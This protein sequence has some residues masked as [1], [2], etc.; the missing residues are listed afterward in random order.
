[1]GRKRRGSLKNLGENSWEIRIQ[2][3]NYKEF[4][5]TVAG[6]EAD[7]RAHL[8][9]CL[10]R[11]AEI[12]RAPEKFITLNVLLDKWLL[13]RKPEIEEK[14]YLGYESS[15]RRYIRPI[16]GEKLIIEIKRAAVADLY[17]DL[18]ARRELSP[19]TIRK[20]HVALNASLNY[21]VNILEYLP[22]NPLDG[23][24][25][26]R[27]SARK[28][29]IPTLDEIRLILDQCRT[30]ESARFTCEQPL[31]L[32]AL[33]TGSR[34]EEYLALRWSEVDL[35]RGTARIE[36][37][38]VELP[39]GFK[40]VKPK[41]E[42][43]RRTLYLSPELCERLKKYRIRLLE[44][45]LETKRR[46]SETDYD[47][48]FPSL[49]GTPMTNSNLCGMFK[50]ILKAANL[51]QDKFSP[52]SLRHACA[53]YTLEAGANLKDISDMLGHSSIRV[54]ADVYTHQTENRKRE[55]A[56]IAA[57]AT[58]HRRKTA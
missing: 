31:V 3:K 38:L 41:T 20:A 12:E 19:L 30:V 15:L 37:A 7:A 46:W 13:Y 45:R 34:P 18:R 5:E 55:V 36:L 53:T 28:K 57:N 25:S 1:M 2:R 16:L 58:M 50:R 44:H 56:E 4:T 11:I 23:L 6:T 21:A 40:F 9:Q 24:K 14:T 17:S 43:S 52:Y 10:I 32:F 33:T 39:G 47:L 27:G 48:V 29:P 8:E 49:A 42:S 35:T 54:T 51:D 26:P 22:K